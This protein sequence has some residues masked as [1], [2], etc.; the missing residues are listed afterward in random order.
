MSS[1]PSL[2]SYPGAEHFQQLLLQMMTPNTEVVMAAST[3]LN[4]LLKVSACVEVLFHLVRGRAA[5]SNH[6][7]P[8][9]ATQAHLV[10]Q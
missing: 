5:S 10:G 3:E 7:L 4:R 8:S 1:D 6:T 2:S 9:L